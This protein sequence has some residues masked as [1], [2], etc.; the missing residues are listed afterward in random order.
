MTMNDVLETI[1]DVREM[2]RDLEATRARTR[3]NTLRTEQ[4][5]RD[6]RL[7]LA[8]EEALVVERVPVLL[9]HIDA[10]EERIAAMEAALQNLLASVEAYFSEAIDDFHDYGP[11]MA[12]FKCAIE[13]ARALVDD[14]QTG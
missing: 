12:W 10:Q 8:V 1:K 11:D 7:L 3:P 6:A 5:Q 9:A 14:A 4:M 2:V 13:E